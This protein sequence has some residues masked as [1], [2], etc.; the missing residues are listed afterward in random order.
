MTSTWL[1]D[2]GFLRKNCFYHFICSSTYPTQLW[3]FCWFRAIS[4][5]RAYESLY[6]LRGKTPNFNLS[7]QPKKRFF[8]QIEFGILLPIFSMY[9]VLKVFL[10]TIFLKNLLI[11]FARQV[12]LKI[13]AY[14]YIDDW[15]II[16]W[17][18]LQYILQVH[19]K[20]NDH[21]HIVIYEYERLLSTEPG[22]CIRYMPYIINNIL[23]IWEKAIQ[24]YI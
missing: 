10:I 19:F 12:A 7:M 21:L 4:T 9:Y 6:F 11:Y 20:K 17:K 16:S 1:C 13:F 5:L 15:K 3:C 22:I 23:F 2:L 14:T 18:C 24:C 8:F